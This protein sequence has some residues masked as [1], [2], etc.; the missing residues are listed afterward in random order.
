[1]EKEE[2]HILEDVQYENYS[3]ACLL[4]ILSE[5]SLDKSAGTPEINNIY[6]LVEQIRKKQ[7]NILKKMSGLV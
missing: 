1:M 3:V 6:N 4:E 7:R 5:Y 2:Y